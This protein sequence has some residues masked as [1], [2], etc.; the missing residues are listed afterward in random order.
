MTTKRLTTA[1][2]TK[3]HVFCFIILFTSTGCNKRIPACDELNRNAVLNPDYTSVTIPPNIA[4]L[5]F[6]INETADKYL[7]RFYNSDGI[8]FTVSSDDGAINIPKKKWHRLLSGSVK[9][10]FFVDI[11]VKKSQKWA[12]YNTIANYVVRDSIDKY[13]VYRLIDPEFETWNV[14]G[15][16]QRNLESFRVTPLMLNRMSDG[17]CVNCH[18]F[19]LNSSK[20]MMFHMRSEHAGTVIYRND[21]LSKINTKTSKTIANGMYPAW[22]PSGNYIAFSVN[23]I[24]Q[25][26]HAIP[27]RTVEVYDTLSNIVLYDINKNVITSCNALSDP[28]RLETFPAWSPDGRYLY[29]CCAKKNVLKQPDY[30]SF[31]DVHSRIRY[32]LLRIAFDQESRSFGAVDTVLIVSDTVSSISLPR[33]SPDGR[34]VLFCKS[35]HGNLT[36]WHPESDLYLLDL[37]TGIVSG[38]DINSNK[39]ESFH[40]WSSTG[41]WIVFSSRRDDGLLYTRPYFTYFDTTGQTHKP[42]VLPQK[43]TKH[44]F[45]IMKSYNLPELVTSKI[46]LNPRKFAGIIKAQATNAAY[47]DF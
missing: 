20:T 11:M 38:P 5:N 7:A 46:D 39:T 29:Y 47:E 30:N 13:L 12:K 32:D 37:N 10:E 28:D 44:Y 24:V 27:G 18:T 8:D 23:N 36:I 6:M 35:E 31:M 42:F 19:C 4:P 21:T 40:T 45:K 17:N 43:S 33:I 41:R 1:R 25:S 14:M 34:Y 2:I 3:L 16:Y 9:G 15:I 26:Y 22:H